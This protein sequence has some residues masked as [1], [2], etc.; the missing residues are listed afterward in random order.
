MDVDPLE[1]VEDEDEKEVK[2]GKAKSNLN[3]WVAVTV[4]VLATFMGICKVK[5][6]NIVQAMQQAQADKID[7][8]SWYQARNVRE[9]VATATAAQLTAQLAAAPPDARAAVQQQIDS[10]NALAKEQDEKKKEQQDAAE[11]ADKTYN[12]LNLHDDQFDL[13]DAALSIAISLLAVTALTQK[14]W[15]YYLALVPTAFGL[16]MGLA[17]LLGWGL[18]PDA[19]ARLLS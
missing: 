10:Y 4:A 15:L 5:D 7:N 17:G 19:L 6:D 16:L 8:Y 1:H 11:Q 12:Q 2:N 9:E 3:R 14:R 18:H 13:T